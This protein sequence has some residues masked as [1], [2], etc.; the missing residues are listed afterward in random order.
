M[1]PRRQQIGLEMNFFEV[2]LD[3]IQAIVVRSQL[4]LYNV[5]RNITLMELSYRVLHLH[6]RDHHMELHPICYSIVASR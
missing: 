3:D 2:K 5:L 1:L 6:N 4:V